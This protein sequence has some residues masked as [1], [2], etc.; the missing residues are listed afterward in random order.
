MVAALLVAVLALADTPMPKPGAADSLA[1]AIV[2]ELHLNPADSAKVGRIRW[3]QSA[4]LNLGYADARE[5]DRS[6][7]RIERVP[8]IGHTSSNGREI[9]FATRA[10]DPG[11]GH[12][13]CPPVAADSWADSPAI[14]KH[15]LIHALTGRMDHPAKLFHPEESRP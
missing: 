11:C 10:G 5:Y 4:K 13:E 9:T 3:M 2:R 7:R 6:A 1:G 8:I 15:E 14:L 12:P